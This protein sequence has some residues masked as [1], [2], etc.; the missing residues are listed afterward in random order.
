MLENICR[1]NVL[2]FGPA[3]NRVSTTSSREVAKAKIAPDT[4]PGIASGRVTRRNT[5][6]G[7]APRLLA[8]RSIVGSIP[9]RAAETLTITKGMHRTACAMMTP[10]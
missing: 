10:R 2:W 9:C 8:A 7:R 1:A 3:T 6:T 5:V 4:T